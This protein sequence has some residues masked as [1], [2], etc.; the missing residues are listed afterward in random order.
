MAVAVVACDSTTSPADQLR[1]TTSV[2]ASSF[3]VG[4]RVDVTIVARNMGRG[5]VRVVANACAGGFT[6]S[7]P[8]GALVGPAPK[9]CTMELAVREL[10][11][12]ES[13]TIT[14]QWTG[15]A[16]S[17]AVQS[18]PETVAPGDYLIRGF[19]SVYED[20]VAQSPAVEIQVV[21]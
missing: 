5:S 16:R 2:S 20:G 13:Y 9:V 6:V 14:S 21:P 1:V 11:P 10:A 8:D 18:P 12:G 15:D 4:V 17:Q 19:V 3:K 7:T